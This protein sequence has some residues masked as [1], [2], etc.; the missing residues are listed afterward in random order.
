[1]TTAG[2]ARLPSPHHP[3]GASPAPPLPG[4]P[5]LH[6]QDINI[7]LVHMLEACEVRQPGRQKGY[8]QATPFS[9]IQS[10]ICEDS[11]QLT[12]LLQKDRLLEV[13][14][15]TPRMAE[16]HERAALAVSRCAQPAHM[17]ALCSP[18]GTR[19]GRLP[20]LGASQRTVALVRLSTACMDLERFHQQGSILVMIGFLLQMLPFRGTFAGSYVHHTASINILGCSS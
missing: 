17:A 8:Y 13:E 7:Y 1:M 4:R 16:R 18:T 6:L 3:G 14:A 15:S 19:A 5:G 9:R 10:M 12:L 2:P 11:A 20:D